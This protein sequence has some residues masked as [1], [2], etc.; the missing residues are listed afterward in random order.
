MCGMMVVSEDPTV[1]AENR[2]VCWGK[3]LEKTHGINAFIYAKG[4]VSTN[5]FITA[6]VCLPQLLA[7]T[8][9]NMYVIS[10]GHNDAYLQ[11][12]VESFKSSY[13]SIL[14]SIKSH[15]P[16]AKIILC[17]Q[18]KGYGNLN[19]GPVLNNAISEIGVEYGIPVLNPEDDIYLY[20]D[21]YVQTQVHRHPTLVGY[22]ALAGAFERLFN[23]ATIDYF[24]YFRD[25]TGL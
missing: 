8:P 11:T 4:G 21:Y 16:K 2:N 22:S 13:K 7:D 19:N 3:I 15:A 6:S 9:K 25:Y 18:S 23:Q 10:L 24:E 12:P 14:D 1:T 20:S 17:R 5:D